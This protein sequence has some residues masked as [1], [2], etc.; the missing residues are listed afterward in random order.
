MNS[1]KLNPHIASLLKKGQD[2]NKLT[3]DMVNHIVN[4]NGGV[5]EPQYRTYGKGLTCDCFTNTDALKEYTPDLIN[6]TN[7][8]FNEVLTVYGVKPFEVWLNNTLM[9][10]AFCGLN[11]FDTCL[12]VLDDESKYIK[13]LKPLIIDTGN[14]IATGKRQVPLMMLM[15]Y[16]SA[17]I[18]RKR[19]ASERD[20][21]YVGEDD[22]PAVTRV[23]DE[24]HFDGMNTAS[25]FK[26]WLRQPD[27]V[28]DF[29]KAHRML[30]GV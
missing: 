10:D 15:Q 4:H 18:E 22:A 9:R 29:V 13:F 12:S 20:N 7:F 16:H 17:Y 1:R 14:F 23:F 19:R 3:P 5:S 21:D 6:L 24:D 26:T 25:F 11:R 27:G 8:Y 30:F 2:E 28:N